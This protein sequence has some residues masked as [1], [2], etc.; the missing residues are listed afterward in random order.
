MRSIFMRRRPASFTAAAPPSSS[1]V[2]QSVKPYR[3][4]GHQQEG[5]AH[6]EQLVG[7]G[8]F[9]FIDRPTP[10]TASA[11][12][13]LINSINDAVGR[14][15]PQL[16]SA[17]ALRAVVAA[18]LADHGVGAAFAAF[19]PAMAGGLPAG[20]SGSSSGSSCCCG[21]SARRARM[22]CTA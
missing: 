11:N 19:L 9:L 22:L 7:E 21:A 4:Q 3:R 8:Q 20:I 15:Q 17:P 16:P 13:Y 5:R 6:G 1:Q 14:P 18:V 2:T 12:S 10:Y